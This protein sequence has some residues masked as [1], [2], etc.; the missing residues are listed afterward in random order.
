M[1][2]KFAKFA[3]FAIFDRGPSPRSFFTPRGRSASM[4]D[5]RREIVSPSRRTSS[6]PFKPRL[7]NVQCTRFKRGS[8]S[9]ALAHGTV[10]GRDR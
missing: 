8:V 9:E 6:H 5:V 2:A 7:H 1:F 3:K 4:V 10:D